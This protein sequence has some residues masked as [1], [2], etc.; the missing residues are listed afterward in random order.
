M[1][2]NDQPVKENTVLYGE[3]KVFFNGWAKM[4]WIPY[5]YNDG[6]EMAFP[7]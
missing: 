7:D 1:S 4:A 5:L 3:C 2:E 6:V